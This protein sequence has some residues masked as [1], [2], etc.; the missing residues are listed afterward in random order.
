M[1]GGSRK[2][3]TGERVQRCHLCYPGKTPQGPKPGHRGLAP[4]SSFQ[5]DPHIQLKPWGPARALPSPS[6]SA[7]P[8]AARSP[9]S[10]PAQGPGGPVYRKPI[11]KYSAVS[12]EMK[13]GLCKCLQVFH[14]SKSILGARVGGLSFLHKRAH[15]SFSFE[16]IGENT[17]LIYTF[18]S[19]K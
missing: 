5:G 19:Q 17:W 15:I 18:L 2:V 1:D 8:W 12:P 13:T 16:K 7:F 10:P 9:L 6:C 3:P 11:H 14:V 4:A